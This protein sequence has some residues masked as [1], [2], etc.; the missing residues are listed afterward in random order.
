LVQDLFPDLDSLL[1]I[2]GETRPP[3]LTVRQR[4][5]VD[6]QVAEAAQRRRLLALAAREEDRALLADLP[7]STVRAVLPALTPE[8]VAAFADRRLEQR[9]VAR[10][11][12]DTL[13]TRLM[14][15]L[16]TPGPDPAADALWRR[17]RTGPLGQVGERGIPYGRAE[18]LALGHDA[19][20]ARALA[21]PDLWHTPFYDE[22]PLLVARALGVDLVVVQPD[23]TGGFG[24]RSL[25]P[26]A[27]G[28]A[29]H[30][31]Y[32]GTDHYR[33]LDPVGTPPQPSPAT[34]APAPRVSAP[35]APVPPASPQAPPAPRPDQ[36][37]RDRLAELARRHGASETYVRRLT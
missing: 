25:D 15:M 7:G 17:V 23:G 33:S 32:N 30:V 4:D 29:V 3:D 21:A 11:Q 26:E 27:T 31:H 37:D 18:F 5:R 20:V 6:A 34:A 9:L 36:G 12:T 19:L 1:G 35:P 14:D 8:E 10:Q 16:R 2:L 13:R 24:T 28:P 22:V